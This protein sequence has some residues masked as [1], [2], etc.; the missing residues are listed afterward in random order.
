MRE[1][2]AGDNEN[3]LAWCQAGL[4]AESAFLENQSVVGWQFSWNPEKDGNKYTHDF[5][6]SCP[7]DLKTA[8]TQWRLSEEMFGIPADKAVSINA[9][10]FRRYASL[11][12]NIII[13]VRVEWLDKTFMLTIPRARKLVAE[14][15]AKRHE[16]KNR[17]D[18]TA[19]NAKDSYIFNLDDLDELYEST[20]N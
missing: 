10:D 3:K 18:D 8:G 15:R 7:V 9:K 20:W 11:Y 5:V 14:G 16:Y 12:P 19:G 6:A 17:K 4:V 2:G 1:R 13:V